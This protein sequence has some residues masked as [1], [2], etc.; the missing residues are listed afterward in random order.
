MPEDPDNSGAPTDPQVT[1]TALPPVQPTPDAPLLP[2]PGATVA[3]PAP[4]TRPG[5]PPAEPP[6]GDDGSVVLPLPLPTIELPPLLPGLPGI[7]IG[8]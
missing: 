3:V 6:A 8:E 2:L 1:G 4:T 7:R 5:E